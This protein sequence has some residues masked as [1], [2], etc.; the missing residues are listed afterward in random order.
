MREKGICPITIRLHASELARLD[1]LAKM[2][3]RNRSSVIRRLLNLADIPEA[4]RLLGITDPKPEVTH[5][6]T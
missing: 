4:R 5:E 6:K 1:R 2:G 3:D